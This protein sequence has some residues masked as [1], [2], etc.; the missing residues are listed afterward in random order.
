MQLRCIIAFLILSWC[1]EAQYSFSG[2]TNPNEWQKTVYL[3]I[4]E[5]YRKMSGV[6]SE[7]IIAKTTADETGFFE[8]KGDMLNAENR[9]YRIH[10]DK[11]TETQQDVNHFNGYCSDSEELLFIAKNTDT[12]KLPFSFGNQVFCKVESNNPRAN[13]FL[14]IDSLKNDM[15]FAYGEVRSEA[16]RKLNN[17]K[18]FTT[19]QDYG[20]ALNEPIAELGIYAYLSDRSS[21]LHSYYVEDLKNNPYYDGLK[22]RLETAY[23]NAP[24]TTQYKN[25]LAADRFMLA[26]AEEDKNSSFNIYLY[27][28]LAISFFL[29]LFLLYRIWKNK[30]SKSEDL[31]SRLSKQEQVVL[32]HLL[33]DKSNKDIAES[34]FLSVST[35]KTHTNNIY[36]KLDVQSRDEAKSLFIK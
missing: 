15:R 9:I 11:C 10:V 3:S 36:K 31:R 28:V 7:Q 8:F 1:C 13:A 24:Y 35:I 12:L 4:V 25:E 19:L 34:L 2:Y 5:D 17:K 22:E 23:P 16:N 20:T 32:E 21:Y 14:K 30:H 27:T 18:W 26:T 6:Y 29:N 33:Q